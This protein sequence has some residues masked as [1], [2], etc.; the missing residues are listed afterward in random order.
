MMKPQDEY[1][2]AEH[3][4]LVSKSHDK[5]R[6]LLTIAF[7]LLVWPDQGAIEH[8]FHTVVSVSCIGPQTLENQLGSGHRE[9]I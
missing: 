7:I 2:T 4:P 3:Q 6:T 5:D 1:L 8:R 9:F